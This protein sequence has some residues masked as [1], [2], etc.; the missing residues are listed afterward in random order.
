VEP[1]LKGNIP[2]S[3]ENK[4]LRQ[5]IPNKFIKNEELNVENSFQFTIKKEMNYQIG[6]NISGLNIKLKNGA[7]IYIDV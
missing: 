1:V 3:M 4:G 2:K 7:L 6:E 5:F